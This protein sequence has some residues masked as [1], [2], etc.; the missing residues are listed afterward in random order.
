[1]TPAHD[2]NLEG[3]LVE[4]DAVYIRNL[5]FTARGR[6]QGRGD[7]EYAVVIKIEARYSISRLWLL[8][9]FFKRNGPSFGVELHHAIT[10]RVVDRICKH[11]RTVFFLRGGLE[12]VC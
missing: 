6:L 12:I 7:I 3:S 1:M 2:A 5:E 8:R 4:I 9:F 10:C 11:C